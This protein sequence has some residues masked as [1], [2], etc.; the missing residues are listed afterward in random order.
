MQLKLAQ[1]LK[2]LHSGVQQD[3]LH[4]CG[5]FGELRA[6]KELALWLLDPDAE[7]LF[8]H[9]ALPCGQTWQVSH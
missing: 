8:R 3:R 9:L 1:W 5:R 2:T 7:S 6:M 4:L